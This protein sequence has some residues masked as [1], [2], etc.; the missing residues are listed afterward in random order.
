MKKST[1]VII[2]VSALTLFSQG[3]KYTICKGKNENYVNYILNMANDSINDG[4]QVSAHRGFS[5]KAIENTKEAIFLA[6]NEKY[7]DY[8]EMDA[9]LTKDG[10]IILSHDAILHNNSNYFNI[11]NFSYDEALN[12]I[13]IYSK[14]Y[15]YNNLWDHPEKIMINNRLMDLD[16]KFYQLISLKEALSLIKNKMILLDLKF[17]NDISL[18]TEKLQKELND[19]DTSNIIIQ[20][21][22]IEGIKYVQDHTNFNCQV[23]ISSEKDLK[24]CNDFLRIGLNYHL[25]NYEL[26][27]NLIKNNK[28]VSLWTINNTHDLEDVLNKVGEYYHDIIFITD[29]PDLIAAKLHEKVLKK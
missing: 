24:Y 14:A 22:N 17:N 6:N 21:L 7:I 23:L 25:V 2:Y 9:R 20:S 1:K 10:E 5:S 18:F 28:K 16:G 8:I 3:I 19:F 26:I 11:T 4:I 27:D 15:G 13:F 29:Y 12:T